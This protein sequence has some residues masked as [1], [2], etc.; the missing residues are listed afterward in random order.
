MAERSLQC[1]RG[2]VVRLVDICRPGDVGIGADQEGVGWSVI[3]FG[4]VDGDAMLP[5]S[6]DLAE[7]WAV[8]EVEGDGQDRRRLPVGPPP[9]GG[10][11]ARPH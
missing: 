4:G 2:G 5:V 9:A 3:G 8:G 10:M 7:V 1:G 6:G 11:G